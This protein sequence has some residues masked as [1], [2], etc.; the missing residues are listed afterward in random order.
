MGAEVGVFP[1][2]SGADWRKAAEA[3]LKGKSLDA[4]AAR[5]ADG[6][7]IE[8][9][10]PPAEGPRALRAEGSWRIMARL[11][12]PD[13][14][15]ANAQALEDLAG[16][17]DGLQVVFSGA[18]GGYGF[19]LRR[20]DSPSLHAAFEGV[21]FEGGLRFELDLGRQGAE[22]ARR[23]A[24][25]IERSGARA[26]DCAVAFGL[27]PFAW[28]AFG[29]FPADWSAH[30]QPYLDAA[31]TLRAEGFRRPAS[32]RRRTG[33]AR[34]RRRAGAGTRFRAR[35]RRQPHAPL[36]GRGRSLG[37]GAAE[38]FVPPRGGCGRIRHIVEVSRP[39]SHVGAGRGGVRSRAA[40]RQYPCRER[41]AHD[42]RAGSVRERDARRDGRVFGGSWRGRQHQ[43]AA[44]YA[45]ARSAG[46]SGAAAG[47]QRPAH[48]LT[49]IQPRFRRRPRRGCG[50]IRGA[51]P[52]ARREGLV[53]LSGSGGP[54]RPA[55]S[56]GERRVPASGCGERG[57]A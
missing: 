26:A 20:F 41:L 5:T 18:I 22:E 55:R 2:W 8:P 57:G 11:D 45:C 12:H 1:R 32:R 50:R 54:G 3:A 10:Y 29:P 38:N 56:P 4:L 40:L 27:D 46:Q 39:S 16:A 17:A 36:R 48:S 47:A 31:L 51:D 37:R 21:R 43:R 25:L 15:E 28:S 53:A 7:E 52:G 13:P 19:G 24:S 6:I 30:A 14:G 33:G 44:A 35:G 42:D 34:R 49:R 9:L 23:F